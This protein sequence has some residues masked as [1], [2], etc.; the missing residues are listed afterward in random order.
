MIRAIDKSAPHKNLL[1]WIYSLMFCNNISKFLMTNFLVICMVYGLFFPSPKT[2][3]FMAMVAEFVV[4]M[5]LN[6]MII[7]LMKK[8]VS[9]KDEDDELT[10]PLKAAYAI[11]IIGTILQVTLIIYSVIT[12]NDFFETWNKLSADAGYKYYLL[13]ILFDQQ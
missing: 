9:L 6:L 4:S 12:I 5:V 8:A 1:F 3:V 10:S 13:I 11:F 2:P 7:Y